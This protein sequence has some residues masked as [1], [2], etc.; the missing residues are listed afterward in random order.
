MLARMPAAMHLLREKAR[1][2]LQGLLRNLFDK[3]DDALFELADQATNNH[4]QNLYFDSMRQVRLHRKDTEAAFFHHVDV[5][6]ARLM[7]AGAF[8]EA[9]KD[10]EAASLDNLSL[11]ENDELE[12]MVASETMI[13]RANEQFAERVQH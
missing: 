7:D 11:V 3:A 4:E 8:P 2:T 1:Q 6:F 5:G 9:S 13:N 12:E 10:D